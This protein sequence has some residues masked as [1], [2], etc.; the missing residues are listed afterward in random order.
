MKFV[1][2]IERSEIERRIKNSQP[3]CAFE[4]PLPEFFLG[5]KSPAR[6]A[7]ARIMRDGHWRLE[8]ISANCFTTP[9]FHK[10]WTFRYN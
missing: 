3:A 5:G 7:T 4:H 2:D 9:N 6:L 1:S 10:L 8:V